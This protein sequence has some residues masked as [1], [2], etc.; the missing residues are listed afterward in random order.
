MALPYKKDLVGVKFNRLIVVEFSHSNK[1]NGSVWKCLCECGNETFVS[2]SV[3]NRGGAVSCGCYHR[4]VMKDRKTHGMHGTVFYMRWVQMKY[5][6]KDINNSV[7]GG[8]GIDYAPEWEIF[9]NFKIDM[10]DTFDENLELDRIDVTLGYS[11]ENCRW[12]THGEN[13]FN[14]NIQ[15]NNSSGKTGVSY[16]NRLGKWRA[17]I[18]V[19]KRQISL[20][21]YDAFEL[22]VDARKAAELE[23]YG[24]YRP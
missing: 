9:E 11:K 18:T 17:Y 24:Y 16:S 6:C 3:I 12:V 20:G 8:K 1:N 22:A 4:E 14:K 10:Y 19:N 7:Y 23:H 5:R 13:N 2:V 15:V 21:C